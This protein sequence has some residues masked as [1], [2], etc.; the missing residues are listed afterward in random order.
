MIDGVKIDMSSI[1]FRELKI[2][3]LLFIPVL[4]STSWWISS[5][6]FTTSR[7]CIS[8]SCP[9]RRFTMR[10]F[11]NWMKSLGQ[12][13]RND[14]MKF[15]EYIWNVISVERC[16]VFIVQKSNLLFRFREKKNSGNRTTVSAK[17]K[18]VD[19]FRS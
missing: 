7:F 4:F 15:W 11:R 1:P 2:A 17:S 14:F 9:P 6:Y 16:C 5:L 13:L 3:L 19:C 10:L 18:R 8:C 12:Y